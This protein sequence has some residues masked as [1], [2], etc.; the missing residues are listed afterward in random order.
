MVIWQ[1]LGL[2]GLLIPAGL[3]YLAVHVADAVFG[4]GYSRV[5]NWPGAAAVLLGAV[6]VGLLALWLNLLNARPAPAQSRMAR[7]YRGRHTLFFAPL[8]Y[9]SAAVA[10]VAVCMTLRHPG[11]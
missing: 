9:V 1:G 7:I 10:L 3:Y 11:L 5:H 8:P 2:L 4:A 6:L